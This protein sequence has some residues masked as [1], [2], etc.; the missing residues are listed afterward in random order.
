M[1]IAEKKYTPP[2]K[3]AVYD[4]SG[5][6]HG[7]AQKVLEEIKSDVERRL[8]A[9]EL[10]IPALPTVA[11]KLLQV[12]ND[13]AVGM[14]EIEK[15]IR[16]D[17]FLAGKILALVNS[18]YRGGRQISSL[19]NA[20]N[21]LGLRTL[22]DLT[23]SLS[24]HQKIF[25]AKRYSELM[26][27]N[28]THSVASALACSLIA[29]RVKTEKES[30]F[31]CGL[32]HDIG[33]PVLLN[34][35]IQIE[36]SLLDGKEIGVDCVEILV[37][38][39]HELVGGYVGKRWNLAP[40]AIDVIRNHH[41]PARSREHQ[42]LATVVYCGD[43]IAEH[44]GYGREAKECAFTLDRWFNQLGLDDQSAIDEILEATRT[45]TTA[46]LGTFAA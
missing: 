4:V 22:R 20:V 10:E 13:P 44:L 15:L 27:G 39:F 26:Q 9:Q 29:D 1:S 37:N 18:A 16:A 35:I 6:E 43:K 38:D 19:K 45:Q 17:Q 36:E 14:E 42:A 41:D 2:K 8:N 5:S 46:F 40:N 30:A 3:N 12:S 33:S 32:L 21:L 34:S 11:S 25:A 7:V 24:L 23:F 31:L 28:W